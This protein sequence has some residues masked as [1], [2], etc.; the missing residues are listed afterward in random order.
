MIE[1]AN[2]NDCDYICDNVTERCTCKS[3][4]IL[5]SDGKTCKGM[6]RVHILTNS[7]IY[8]YRC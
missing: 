5:E 4:F 1:C 6:Y 7:V 3:G 2:H 8:V